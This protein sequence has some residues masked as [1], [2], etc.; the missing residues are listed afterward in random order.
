MIKSRKPQTSW[1]L[2]TDNVDPYDTTD[3]P[4]PS[5]HLRTGKGLVTSLTT[6]SSFAWLLKSAGD[7]DW[8]PGSSRSP[9]V[10]NGN[11][12]QYSC[13]KTF[14]GQKMLAGFSPWGPEKSHKFAGFSGRSH[15]ISLHGP[16]INLSLLQAHVLCV[17]PHSALRV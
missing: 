14:H 17:W 9:G 11:P 10:E 7:P 13:L 1:S 12:L 2:R 15:R 3:V 6:P 4:A 16:V 5:V 8:I